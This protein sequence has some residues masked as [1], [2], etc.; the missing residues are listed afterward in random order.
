MSSAAILIVDD[1]PDIRELLAMTIRRMGFDAYCAENLDSAQRMLERRRF[2]FCLT[3]MKLPDGNG[4]Q[5]IEHVQQH[6]EGLPVAVITAFGS[7]DLAIESMKAGAF[8][9]LSKP[10]DLE[11]LRVLVGN[12][13]RVGSADTALRHPADVQLLGD[14]EPMQSLRA[15]IARL[16]RSQAPVYI[17]GESGTGKEMVA[18]LIHAN[19]PRAS[20]PFVPVNC[21][22]IPGELME[23]EFFGHR[24]GSFTGAIN[25]KQGLFQAAHGG[26]LFLDEVADLPLPMQVKLLRAIQE[27]AVRAIGAEQEAR[28]DV[29]ILSAT[30]KNLAEEI[31]HGRFRRD[32]FYRINVIELRVPSLRERRADI[33]QLAEA[34]IRRLAS[35]YGQTAPRLQ[36]DAL[37]ALDAYAFPGNV[38]E[39]ENVLE[40]AFTLCDGRTIHAGDLCLDT[41]TQDISRAQE[42]GSADIGLPDIPLEE[43]LE[44]LER[45]IIVRALE[46]ERWNRTAAAKRLG[47]SFRSLRYRLQKLGID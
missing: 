16:A 8:D 11:R 44:N 47:M 20:A 27:K 41:A 18:R 6:H 17:T 15:Q 35:E 46:L 25:D 45:R 30:H 5:F 13:L 38:R 33:P 24:K 19:G 34:C 1:E 9:F 31:E 39:L 12:A 40:R 3:D 2:D 28:V 32:L 4:L 36:P 37:R 26:T 10:I 42:P 14:T 23:S 43:Y 21:G 7:I 22:A 29:R